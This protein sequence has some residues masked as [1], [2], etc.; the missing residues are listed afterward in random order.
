MARKMAIQ[1]NLLYKTSNCS[2]GFPSGLVFALDE[3]CVYVADTN[4]HAIRCLNLQRPFCSTVTGFERKRG[5]AVGSLDQTL[6]TEPRGIA[7]SESGH[8]I[9]ATRSAVYDLDITNNKSSI[10]AGKHTTGFKD[11]TLEEALPMYLSLIHIC[12]CRRIERCRSRG[13]PYH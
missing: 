13:S 7:M 4:N 5:V 6:M 10:I 1:R 3:C 8:L 2:F 11:G 9:V 12:R